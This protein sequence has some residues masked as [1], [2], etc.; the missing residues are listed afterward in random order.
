[1]NLVDQAIA[2][3][4]K[5]DADFVCDVKAARADESFETGADSPLVKFLAEAS[6]KPLST[7]AFGT[8]APSMISLGADA[9]VFGPGDIRMAHRT[10]EF[11]PINE[12]N[13]CVKILGKAIE[14]FCL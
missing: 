12:L 1:L 5:S 9:V 11:V 2:D 10:G 14:H 6:A 7:I 13:Q 3:L 4:K 8:E